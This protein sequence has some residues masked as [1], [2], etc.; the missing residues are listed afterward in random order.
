M[1]G[2]ILLGSLVTGI[3]IIIGYQTQIEQ[4]VSAE[5]KELFSSQQGSVSS[6][7]TSNTAASTTSG[8]SI[9][10]TSSSVDFS[11][12]EIKESESV[13][14]KPTASITTSKESEKATEESL[15]VASQVV[16]EAGDKDQ[17]SVVPATK[18][19]ENYQISVTKN[20]TT[21]EFI[22]TIGK[23]AQA[24]AWNE[25]LYASVMIAQAILETGSGNSQL[26][27]PPYHNLFGIKGS[28]QG[29]QVSF[30][31]QEDEGSGQLYTIHSAFRQYPSYKDSLED[32]AALLKK[33]LSGNVGFYQGTWKSNAAT[34]Q[35]AAKALT[36]KYATDTAYDKK[37]I[38]LIEAYN[39]ASYD[40]DLATND[41]VEQEKAATD[42]VK[43]DASVEEK[44]V[45]EYFS[46]SSEQ[47]LRVNQTKQ[48]VIVVP[49]AAQRPAKQLT[50]NRIVQ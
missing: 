5:T 28:Y 4:I 1:K 15:A 17:I 43:L 33:G 10:S 42:Q 16:P 49:P 3:F 27:R 6:M 7:A 13:E 20:Q 9:A 2:K 23:D 29:K 22:Q 34:F 46:E 24:I 12:E 38:A 41:E 26:A 45:P 37:L 8:K 30:S 44:Q 36:G 48:P 25:D 18:V 14:W 39:L 19:E 11:T 50:G 47:K 31:T 35:E 21:E 40:Q 32:Y